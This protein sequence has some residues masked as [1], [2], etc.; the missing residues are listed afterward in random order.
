MLAKNGEASPGG[1]LLR[2]APGSAQ[3]RRGFLCRRLASAGR[4]ALSSAPCGSCGSWTR[5]CPSAVWLVQSVWRSLS[6][7]TPPSSFLGR[8]CMPYRGEAE[9]WGHLSR[10]RRMGAVSLTFISL[11]VSAHD[12]VIRVLWQL[13][14]SLLI[15]DFG[16]SSGAAVRARSQAAPRHQWGLKSRR[17]AVDYRAG[18]LQCGGHLVPLAGEPNVF[19]LCP[20]TIHVLRDGQ[21]PP[22]L[23][24]VLRPSV[25]VAFT[26]ARPVSL[27]VKRRSWGCAS[28]SMATTARHPD[29]RTPDVCVLYAVASLSNMPGYPNSV[30]TSRK[31]PRNRVSRGC[32]RI[33]GGNRASG[34]QNRRHLK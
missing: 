19:P 24:R 21:H 17:E 4:P 7:T 25:Q 18:G 5:S 28:P 27:G 3:R 22:S 1:A 6:T 32:T 30:A 16:A 13:S 14:N 20:S 29:P 9:P 15:C 31:L 33:W 8:G 12:V 11:L 10:A 23:H 34:Y 26:Y 2:L